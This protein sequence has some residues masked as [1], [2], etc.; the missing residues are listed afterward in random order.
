MVESIV[1]GRAGRFVV[2]FLVVACSSLLGCT[3]G[4][5]Y[6]E[7]ELSVPAAFEDLQP[8]EGA[9]QEAAP[10]PVSREWWK[11]FNDEALNALISRAAAGN[12]DLAAA[13]SRINQSRAL[14]E[15]AFAELLPSGQLNG[16]YQLNRYPA[17][18]FP[19]PGN[20]GFHTELFSVGSSV[21]WEL[22]IFGRVRRGVEAANAEYDAAV[23]G[24]QDVLRMVMADT[25]QTYFQLRSAQAELAIA[26]QNAANQQETY[27][28]AVERL[29]LGRG[30][31]LDLVRAEAQLETTRAMIPLFRAAAENAIHRLCVLV[32]EDP[33]ALHGM[34]SSQAAIPLYQGPVALGEPKD[35]LRRRPDLRAAE[36]KLA[37]ASARAGVAAGDLYPKMSF[38]GTLSVVAETPNEFTSGQPLAYAGG[39]QISWALFDIPKIRARIKASDARTEEA[40]TQYEQAVLRALQETEDALSVF[41]AE[42]ERRQSVKQAAAAS[43]R[44]LELARAQY[45]IGAVDFLSVLAAHSTLLAN[46]DA[47]ARSD[48]ALDSA[49]VSIYRA[50]GGGWEAYEVQAEK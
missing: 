7:P 30:S 35:L 16:A 23:A 21:F 15:Q 24:L 48:L 13:L 18:E 32:G 38:Q 22:D 11:S 20:T 12:K 4:R 1:Q 27:D 50:L 6:S 49:F 45:Q 39:P 2:L 42:R 8:D 14:A 29:K 28:N 26:Q 46:E 5:D 3:V 31:E 43:R 41:S 36:R 25:A 47:L 44:A 9:A 33:H 34:L 17:A 40:L 37:A 19:F 10:G